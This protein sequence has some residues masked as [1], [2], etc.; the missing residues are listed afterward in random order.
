MGLDKKCNQF[1]EINQECDECRHPCNR[2]K[3]KMKNPFTY[4]VLVWIFIALAFIGLIY[5]L[6]FADITNLK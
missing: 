1:T 5:Y 4:V 3:K 6:G 2:G